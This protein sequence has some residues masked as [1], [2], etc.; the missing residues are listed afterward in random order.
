[1]ATLIYYSLELGYY[2]SL[3]ELRLEQRIYSEGTGDTHKAA[4]F[5]VYIYIYIYI[6]IIKLCC[7]YWWNGEDTF[8]A[9]RIWH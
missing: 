7:L 5:F 6:Y 2:I 9:Y 4:S 1:V 8:V 3:A